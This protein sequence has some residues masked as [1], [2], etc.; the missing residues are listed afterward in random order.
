M[1]PP[2]EDIVPAIVSF[3]ENEVTFQRWI[4]LYQADRDW[5]DPLREHCVNHHSGCKRAPRERNFWPK[6]IIFIDGS[7]SGKLT[8]VEK[9]VLDEDYLVLSHCW[10]NPTPDDKTRFCTTLENHDH[11]LGGFSSDDLPKT[12]QDA[13]EVTRALGKQYLWIDALCI[14]P[15]D[16]GNWES[17]ANTMPDIFANAYCTIAVTSAHSWKDGFLKPQSGPLDRQTQNYSTPSPCECDFGKD[18]DSGPLMKRAWVL[19]ERVLSRRTIHFTGSHVYCECGE[20]VICEQLTKLE[21]PFGKQYFI[22]DPQFPG[23][24][25]CSG[26]ERTVQFIQFLFVIYSASGI[27]E[28]TDRAVAIN[29]LIIRIEQKLETSSHYGIFQLFLSSLLLWKR[30]QDSNPPIESSIDF[31]L[32]PTNHFLVPSRNDLCFVDDGRALN[33]EVRNFGEGCRTEKRGAEYVILNVVE[34]VG[35]IWVNMANLMQLDDCNC[36]FVGTLSWPEDARKDYYILVIRDKHGDISQD[37]N[38]GKGGNKDRDKRYERV[39]VGKVQS[40]FVSIDCTSGTL[41]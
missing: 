17:Q 26:Y 8:L 36:V 14:I 24:L 9:Q 2:S 34:E 27:T 33:I 11:R 10:G 28:E 7:I 32:K 23:R 13:I 12:F 35:S 19:Q 20:A 4:R 3:L 6:R 22:L 37:K 16:G 40:R 38:G 30:T 31:I 1:R 41:W 18:V 39:G 29:S 15:G 5:D 21:P 25:Y